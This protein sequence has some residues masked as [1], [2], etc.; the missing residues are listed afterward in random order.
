VANDDKL[1]GAFLTEADKGVV[2]KECDREKMRVGYVEMAGI[3]LSIARE[4]ARE[5]FV[6]SNVTEYWNKN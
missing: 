6:W 3:N 4:T 5:E 2:S 1:T